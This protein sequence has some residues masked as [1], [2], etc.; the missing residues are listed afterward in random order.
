[1]SVSESQPMLCDV[2]TA[3][4]MAELRARR[5]AV[6]DAGPAGGAGADLIEL[7]LD[8]VDRPDVAGALQGRRRPVLV[9]CRAVWEGGHFKGSEDE[10]QRILRDALAAGAEYVDIEWKAR[11]VDE[12]LR[13]ED[14]PRVV[15]S[16]HDFDH[17]PAD[18]AGVVREM[19]ATGS[20]VVKVAARATTLARSRAAPRR[21]PRACGERRRCERRRECGRDRG[22]AHR[23]DRDGHERRRLAH[24]R[25][26]LPILLDLRGSGGGAGPDRRLTTPR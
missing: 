19:R 13:P 2:I 21:G 17:M 14:R 23:A 22:P 3:P 9:T 8:T 15:L 4:T 24:P 20:G 6:E 10:R 26:P 12:W 5:T 16:F 25:G 1:M 7:R 18:L 11:D